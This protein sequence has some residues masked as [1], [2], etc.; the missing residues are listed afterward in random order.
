M[1]GIS[2]ALPFCLTRTLVAYTLWVG[3]FSILKA[4]RL[5]RT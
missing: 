1:R 3:D 5:Q 2:R 4:L